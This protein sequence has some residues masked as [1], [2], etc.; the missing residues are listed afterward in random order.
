[1]AGYIQASN[2]G[3]TKRMN[4]KIR[5]VFA[6]LIAF[7]TILIDFSL[8]KLG[9]SVWKLS[10]QLISIGILIFLYKKNYKTLGL[11][12]DIKPNFTYWLRMSLTLGS[13]VGLA[14]FSYIA[15]YGVQSFF[16]APIKSYYPGGVFQV[17]WLGCIVAPIFEEP[18][19]RLILVAGLRKFPSWFIVS[20]GGFTFALL[21]F[22]YGNLSPDNAV[23]G[24]VLTWAFLKS[25]SIL[26]PIALHS[27]GNLIVAVSWVMVWGA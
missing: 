9:Y 19:Y 10:Y 22:L 26:V 27:L 4:D 20:V 6:F 15:L 13:I 1:L 14:I 7:S 23:A 18:I 2:E 8:I 3:L 25:E 24:F 16:P 5:P 12:L 21:H 11:S 17:L